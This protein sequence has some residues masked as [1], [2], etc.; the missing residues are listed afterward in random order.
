M[1]FSQFGKKIFLKIEISYRIAPRCSQ[2]LVQEVRW[3]CSFQ[4]IL[5]NVM[6]GRYGERITLMGKELPSF[7]LYLK[8][9]YVLVRWECRTIVLVISGREDKKYK[10]IHARLVRYTN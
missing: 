10:R 9:T 2:S 7:L 3:D 6:V 1:N 8:K 4:R 5:W